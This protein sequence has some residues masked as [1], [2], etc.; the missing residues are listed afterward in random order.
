MTEPGPQGVGADIGPGVE[1]VELLRR[2][3]AV[4]GGFRRLTDQLLSD[5]HDEIGLPSSELQVL[6][7]LAESPEQAAP[8][9][10]LSELLGFST[11]GITGVVDRLVD[12]GLVERRPSRTDRRVTFAA[13]TEQGGRIAARAADSLAA[14]VR[15][16]I[17]EPLGDEGF[18]ALEHAVASL[19]GTADPE[20]GCPGSTTC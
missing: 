9:R 13:L 3:R 14:A 8:M 4:D 2:W 11:A 16:R 17:V 7:F 15:R 20:T 18:T 10:Q 1:E 6:C 5:L 12:A 19:V